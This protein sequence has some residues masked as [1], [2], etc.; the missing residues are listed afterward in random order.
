MGAYTIT[1]AKADGTFDLVKINAKTNEETI[2]GNV[3][4][5]QYPNGRESDEVVAE[6]NRG[7]RNNKLAET[8]W[9]AN[10]DVTMTE[11]QRAYRVALRDLPTHS[12]WPNLTDDDWPTEP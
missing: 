9:W 4:D 10:S 12:N 8:D 2:V 11:A 6:R 1:R 7:F 3:T 5:A